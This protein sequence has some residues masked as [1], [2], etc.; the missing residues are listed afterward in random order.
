MLVSPVGDSDILYFK[1]M[2]SWTG[3]GEGDFYVNKDLLVYS[4]SIDSGYNFIEETGELRYQGDDGVYSYKDGKTVFL[5]EDANIWPDD[6][7]PYTES[8]FFEE[9]GNVYLLD[10]NGNKI[11]IDTGISLL[12]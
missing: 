6:E 9:D 4:M 10:D 1:N 11:L 2:W 7:D 5:G 3:E 12:L 8:A